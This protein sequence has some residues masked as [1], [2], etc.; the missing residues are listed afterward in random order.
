MAKLFYLAEHLDCPN[1]DKE[2]HSAVQEKN[3][4]EEESWQL[5]TL[6]DKLLF[7]LDGKVEYSTLQQ[8]SICVAGGMIL[9]LPAG[10]GIHFRG[11]TKAHILVIRL[12]KRIQLCDC[13]RL[14]D[15]Q[16]AAQTPEEDA[17]NKQ[18]SPFLLR[19][20]AVVRKYLD[21]LILCHR[22]GLRCRYYNEL[23]IRELLFIFRA[24]Y[25]KKELLRFFYPAITGD[26]TF[27][28][29]V[30]ANFSKYDSLAQMAAAMN[31]TVSG[32]EKRFRRVFGCSPYQWKMRREAEEAFHQISTSNIS[33]KQISDTFGFNSPS[34]FNN[35]IK[36]HF[37]KTPGEIRQNVRS[38]T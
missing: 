12:Y 1:Y 19:A 26:T 18:E 11:L 34:A 38:V 9:F 30:M 3:I 23:K 27:S 8:R 4:K 13:F 15:L 20:N 2:E 6:T 28:Q 36:K 22:E 7:V 32:F 5:Q 14:E 37:G 31:Y 33:I 17:R 25:Q 35:F 10:Q 21:M 29:F 16:Q 24:F